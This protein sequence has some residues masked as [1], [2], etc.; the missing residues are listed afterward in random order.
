MRFALLERLG[1]SAGAAEALDVGDQLEQFLLADVALKGRHS[2]ADSRR[3]FAWPGTEWNRGCT[4][5]GGDHLAV[6]QRHGLAVEA[7]QR[8]RA[9]GAV[10]VTTAAAQC[11]EQAL[12]R[13]RQR[14]AGLAA[15]SQSW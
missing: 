4:F 6:L 13:L 9:D 15:C 2:L 7:F 1:G 11:A 12:A 10:A 3:Q 5:V 8:R 14:A